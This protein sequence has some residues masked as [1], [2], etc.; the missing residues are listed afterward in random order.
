L[1]CQRTQPILERT[2]NTGRP[3]ENPVTRVSP[4]PSVK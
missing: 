1:R 4:C 3:A 2:H